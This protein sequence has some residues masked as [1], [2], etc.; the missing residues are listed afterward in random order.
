[1]IGAAFLLIFLLS[2]IPF[3]IQL[4]R[5]MKDDEDVTPKQWCMSLLPALCTGTGLVVLSFVWDVYGEYLWFSELHNQADRFW[6]VFRLK[7]GIFLSSAGATFFFMNWMLSGIERSVFEKETSFFSKLAAALVAI[8]SGLVLVEFWE[9]V[10]LYQAHET[11]GIED[12]IFGKSLSFYLFELPMYNLLY[13]WA[14]SVFGITFSVAG[15]F[16]FCKSLDY[17][18]PTA[19]PWQR[20]FSQRETYVL[21]GLFFILLAFGFILAQFDLMTFDAGI[22][23]GVTYT[24]YH[25]LIPA[26]SVMVYIMLA[27]GAWLITMTFVPKLRPSQLFSGWKRYAFNPVSG[28]FA[29]WIVLCVVVP[30]VVWYIEVRPNEITAEK[31]FIEHTMAFTRAAY[32]IDPTHLQEARFEITNEGLTP[33]DLEVNQ[34]TFANV[35]IWDTRL[36]HQILSQ[37]QTLRNVYR[38]PDIDVDRYCDAGRCQSVMIATREIDHDNLP[39][40]A[41]NRINLRLKYTHGKGIVV[42]PVNRFKAS[43]DPVYYSQDVPARSNVPWLD[44]T[45][46]DIYYGDLTGS[47]VYVGTTEEEFDYASEVG[48]TMTRYDGRGGV[49]ISSWWRRFTYGWKFDSWILISDYFTPESRVMF[50]RQIQARIKTLAP[51]LMMDDDWYPVV[52]EGRL[53]AILDTYTVS[54]GYPYSEGIKMTSLHADNVSLNYIRNAVKA[55]IDLKDGTV[56][57]YVFDEEDPIIG[58]WQNAFPD[59]FVSASRMP[60]NLRAHVRYPEDLFKAQAFIYNAYHVDNFEEFFNGSDKWAIPHE[61]YGDSEITMEPYYVMLQ[62]PGMESPEF[63]LIRPF[64]FSRKPRMTG[65]MAGLSDGEN[66]GKLF[67][68]K[69]PKDEFVPGVAQIEAQIGVTEAFQ[70]DLRNWSRGDAEVIRGNLII[71]PLLGNKLVAFEPVYR[72]A[73]NTPIPKLA[74]VVSAQV[75]PQELRIVWGKTYESSRQQLLAYADSVGLLAADEIEDPE[76]LSDEEL[77]QRV[78][79]YLRS[80]QELA[81]EGNFSAAGSE[82]EKALTVLGRRVK[83]E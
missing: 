2:C 28:W 12:P 25:A 1:M 55:T 16:A 41:Q 64:V 3:F 65:W 45:V 60:E 37:K 46:Q 30:S 79:G 20:V 72:R 8:G 15:C 59:L 75:T 67:A 62:L 26:Y 32:R 56:T 23:K 38:F 6:T 70:E 18:V 47:H 40:H 54:S 24:D 5:F 73:I 33:A 51:F 29:S 63:M 21:G 69:F 58:A 44:L 83:P 42:V 13:G 31:P 17:H 80:H 43:G 52:H 14:L 9:T 19:E 27:L 61:L 68:F 22:V 48:N 76:L 71:L 11:G 39:E 74:R 4:R 49:E 53:I 10:L 50:H 34:E 36:L 81:G 57:L 35:R 82:L 66:Y 78:Y 7:W 77:L